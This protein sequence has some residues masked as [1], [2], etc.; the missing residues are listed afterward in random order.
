MTPQE[1]NKQ[2]C[3]LNKIPYDAKQEP[4]A[5]KSYFL[6]LIRMRPDYYKNPDNQG[7]LQP[8]PQPLPPSQPYVPHVS[9]TD[10]ANISL[11]NALRSAQATVKAIEDL[12]ARGI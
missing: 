11:Q 9:P 1:W 4:N 2:F 12:M 3:A 7:S 8:A 5:N 10:N 6:G